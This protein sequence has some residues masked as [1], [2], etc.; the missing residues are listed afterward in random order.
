MMFFLNYDRKTQKD[1]LLVNYTIF[2]TNCQ[3]N[4]HFFKI[5]HTIIGALYY[6]KSYAE[7]PAFKNGSNKA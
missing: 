4:F 5:K 6:Q 1:L 7:I 3:D 2:G